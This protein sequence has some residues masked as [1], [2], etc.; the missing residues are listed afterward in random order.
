MVS[1]GL[2]ISRMK[3]FYGVHSL[4]PDSTCEGASLSGF[5]GLLDVLIF[6]HSRNQ[7]LFL[8]CGTER[9]NEHPKRF[10]ACWDCN[11]LGER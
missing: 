5:R 1:L 9:R 10:A 4:G 7:V 8:R 3:D 2:A 6:R 11:F